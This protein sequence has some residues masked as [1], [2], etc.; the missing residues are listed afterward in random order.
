[1]KSSSSALL[2]IDVETSGPDPFVH[3][4]L[5][6]AFVPISNCG[7]AKPIVFYIKYP[8]ISW[9]TIGKQYF[10]KY[11][12]SWVNSAK[13]PQHTYK[14][15]DKYLAGISAERVTLVG[16]NVGFDLSFLKQ[17]IHLA[18]G[19]WYEKLTYRT[20]DTYSMSYALSKSKVINL[21]KYDSDHLFKTFNIT[22]SDTE[23]HTS[24][25]DAYAV[26]YL[27]K[28]MISLPK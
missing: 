5:S 3:R 17:L 26:K 7:S 18:K 1:M 14:A 27:Y 23:R 10:D 9:T 22:L 28:R 13:T 25:G 2:A 19:R 16:H 12:A 20:L 8:R 4:V 24:L 6:I 11:K 21:R 15:I